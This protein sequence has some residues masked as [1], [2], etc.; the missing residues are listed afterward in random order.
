MPNPQK[1]RGRT[2]GP[3]FLGT[4]RESCLVLKLCLATR[5]GL[6][7]VMSM[8]MRSKI[9]TNKWITVVLSWNSKLQ[10]LDYESSLFDTGLNKLN[11][12]NWSESVRYIQNSLV[13]TPL[14]LNTFLL[15]KKTRFYIMDNGE[16]YDCLPMV[17]LFSA[18]LLRAKSTLQNEQTRCVA[19]K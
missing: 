12:K 10:T 15:P 6:M 11:W 3:P 17:L 7:R 16:I 1:I 13:S 9:N 4:G 18:C 5:L 14:F 19:S 2:P 8:Y